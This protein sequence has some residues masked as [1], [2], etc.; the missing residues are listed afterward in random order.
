EPVSYFQTVPKIW[1]GYAGF[2]TVLGLGLNSCGGRPDQ[3]DVSSVMRAVAEL[4]VSAEAP[5]EDEEARINLRLALPLDWRRNASAVCGPWIYSPSSAAELT[6]TETCPSE[7][8]Y[9]AD[10]TLNTEKKFGCF[11]LNYG[12]SGG[13]IA[14]LNDFKDSEAPLVTVTVAANV[15]GW[16]LDG[17]VACQMLYQLATNA[18]TGASEFR[19]D[20]ATFT[21]S[22]N[23]KAFGCEEFQ[24]MLNMVAGTCAPAA[25]R[26][27]S[28]KFVSEGWYAL[29]E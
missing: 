18:D 17:A 8:S 23:G 4:F 12:I 19:I 24:E 29:R 11:G 16:Q 2:V 25:A 1:L 22:Y 7:T 9:S 26:V 15:R 14:Y 5:I 28:M 3:Y 6:C 21:C 27:N 13:R 10:C 20:C